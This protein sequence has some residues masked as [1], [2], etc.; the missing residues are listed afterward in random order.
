MKRIFNLILVLILVLSNVFQIMVF[1]DS[2][3]SQ[4]QEPVERIIAKKGSWYSNQMNYDGRENLIIG[5]TGAYDKA[6][7]SGE[8][9]FSL[10]EKTVLSGIYIPY[11]GINIG[12]V[13]IYIVDQAG[14]VYQGF[15]GIESIAGGIAEE[16][17]VMLRVDE[18]FNQSANTLYFFKASSPMI[19]PKGKYTVYLEGGSMPVD[20]YMIKGYNFDA[21]KSYEEKL[22]NWESENKKTTEEFP[23][24]EEDVYVSYGDEDL[25]EQFD[26]FVSKD[27]EEY[28][29]EY[30][31]ESATYRAPSFELD[32]KYVIDEIIFNTWNSGNGAKPGTISIINESGKVIDTFKAQGATL[33][34]VPN[35]M[36]V[37]LPETVLPK[38]TYYLDMSS[39]EALVFDDQGYPIFH[40]GASIPVEPP[41]D[42]TGTYRINL[43]LYKTH[44]LMGPVS[45]EQKS[46]SLEN[47]EIAILDKGNVIEIVGQYEGMAFSQN[48]EVVEREQNKLT[49]KFNFAANLSKLPYKAKIAANAEVTISKDKNDRVN[50]TVG[51]QGFY[52]R[53]ASKDKG[54]DE[55]TYDIKAKGSRV[56]KDLP[57]F[58]LAAL[59]RMGG[60]GN[61]PGPENRT[62]AATG[63]LFP[64]LVGLV[65][66]I[67]Q[68]L[69][70][71]KEIPTKLSVG[72]QAMKDANNSLGKGL[73]SEKEKS[74]WAILAEAMANSDEPDDD[75]YSVGDN[76][77]TSSNTSSSNE[78]YQGY[79]EDE[80]ETETETEEDNT[81]GKP[82]VVDEKPNAEGEEIK[83]EES[84]PG[85]KS[86]TVEVDIPK[87]QWDSKVITT[88]ANGAQELIVKNPK[89]GEWE[90]SETGN[91]FDIEKY[92]KE[93]PGQFERDREFSKAQKDMEAKGET[94]MQKALKEIEDKKNAEIE[95]IQKEI[96]KR[97][98]DELEDRQKNLEW[99]LEQAKHANNLGKIIGDSIKNAGDEIADTAK[100]GWEGAKAIGSEIVDAGKDVWNDPSIL[101]ET[102]KG[103]QK[104][105]EDGLNSAKKSFEE[106]IEDIKKDPEIIWNTIKGTGKDVGEGAKNIGKAVINTLKDP[107]KTWEFVKD[108]V[109]ATDFE[110]SWDPNIPLPKR[111]GH[112]ISGTIKI[113]STIATA[114]QA[115]AALK[116]G[117]GKLS[118]LADD[119]LGMG[120][121]NL[122]KVPMKPG[123]NPKLPVNPGG[124]YKPTGYTP[125]TGGVTSKS[126]KIIQNTA[127]EFG[128]QI[129][130]RPTTPQADAWIKSGK[131]VP[132]EM[133]MKAKT[134]NKLDELLGGPKNSE[135]LVGYYKPKLPPKE[136]MKSLSKETQ[137]EIVDQYV[138]RRREFTKLAGDMK[139]LQAQG[140]YA[141]IDGKVMDMKNGG[142][143][144][145]GDV[146]LFDITNFDGSPVSPSVKKQ[147]MKNLIESDG[148]NVMHED[149][150]SWTKDGTA[151]N[152]K[153]KAKM[154]KDAS[155][156]GGTKPV[157]VN[158]SKTIDN[159]VTTYNPLAG[160]TSNFY[161]GTK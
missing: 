17:D 133:D 67:I 24:G 148:S 107:K 136:I 87:D 78:E 33:G 89:T 39:P 51:G 84:L 48:A 106:A 153:A 96:D 8:I 54:A 127:D 64:P 159:G 76:E 68:G 41:T 81:F 111:I 91:P 135:G 56:N 119:I 115:G 60:V 156:V 109:G 104:D 126:Q 52:S 95:A 42:F 121:K 120:S 75:P 7:I 36:W 132:K 134:L 55:N 14:N 117:A 122:P 15:N 21:Y 58:V 88:T 73:T 28:E 3:S 44:T 145:T 53:A 35:G 6:I 63:M 129:H 131:A 116:S 43:D 19:L 105:I 98:R 125:N 155:G 69:L 144:I 99:E 94:A 49:A 86:E 40:V 160:P 4:P 72:E 20:A 77:K 50:L 22:V 32:N 25:P 108:T 37:V 123:I 154:I 12:K 138:K 85:E 2:K 101:S 10:K 97:K 16:T 150:L 62:Q 128:V 26:I 27:S 66:T 102:L 47:H 11:K 13:E 141:V 74:A 34:S 158:G 65:V 142:K 140:K 124:S 146:D 100:A 71:P 103:T 29:N 23:Y 137:K 139:S 70:K 82:D 38:G 110:K 92:E 161:G 30:A 93:Y 130:T 59:S 9:P 31:E 113:G 151:F 57:M 149:V 157:Y 83:S 118:T 80:V 79:G 90:N 147:V 46:F 152:P 5:Y 61:I 143:F 112:V 45:G 18:E 1:A 114:G